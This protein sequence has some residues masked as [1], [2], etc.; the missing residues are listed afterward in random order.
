MNQQTIQNAG[1]TQKKLLLTFKHQLR[2]LSQFL[3]RVTIFYQGISPELDHELKSFREHIDGRFDFDLAEASMANITG[4][5]LQNAETFKQQ[6]SKAVGQ[7]EHTLENLLGYENIPQDLKVDTANLLKALPQRNTSLYASLPFFEQTFK[8]YQRAME[9]P[10]GQPGSEADFSISHNLHQDIII[11]L[12]ELLEQIS[13]TKYNQ[14][15]LG[16]IKTKLTN[17]INHQQLLECCLGV[18]RAFMAD[19]LKERKYARKFIFELHDSLTKVNGHVSRSV[20][21][22]ESQHLAKGKNNSALREHI[23]DIGNTVTTETDLELLKQQTHECLIKMSKTIDEGEQTGEAEQLVMMQLLSEMKAQLVS[24]EKETAGYKDRLV[25]QKLNSYKDALTSLPNRL[26]YN[27]RVEVEYARWKRHGTGLCLAVLDVDHFK[28]VNDNYGHAAGDKTLR[29][30]AQTIK[31]CLR[32][33]DFLSRWGGEE[34]V[35]LF[36]QSGIDDI[37][38]PLNLISKRIQQIP[39]KF[40][41][42]RVTITISIGAASFMDGDII[43]S[44]FERADNNLFQAKN[45]GRNRCIIA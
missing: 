9:N 10:Q 30:I 20:E 14:Q 37:E 42:Q 29:V 13:T 25:E 36:P 45:T 38:K 27:E 23:L 31:Q 43:E 24:L 7:L 39:F 28:R 32:T 17:G 35:I 8:L 5:L 11:E 15:A 26:A 16:E 3:S 12:R 19:L 18:I 4:F 41:D 2:Q 21:I 22:S 34:F 1:Q 33:S 40:K 6:N 44:V